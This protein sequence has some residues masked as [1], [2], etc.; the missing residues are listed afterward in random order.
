M[1]PK[2][3]AKAATGV[4]DGKQPTAQEAYLFYTIIKNMKGK[5]EIDWAAVAAD[6]GYKTAETAKVS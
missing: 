1:P 5:P 2:A 4:S 6:A 3:V